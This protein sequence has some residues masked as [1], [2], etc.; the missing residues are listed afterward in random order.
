[1]DGRFQM[2]SA[3]SVVGPTQCGKTV[4]VCNLLKLNDIM[5]SKSINNIYWFFGILQPEFLKQ[6]NQKIG[7]QVKGYQGLP[8]NFDMVNSN[9]VIVLD[10]LMAESMASPMVTNLFTKVVHHRQCFL[11]YITQNLFQRGRD[12]RTRALNTHYLVMFK[13]PRDVIQLSYL[14]RQMN[15]QF[16]PAAFKD[17]IEQGPYSYILLDFRQETFEY[18]RIRSRILPQEAP[19]Y[20]YMSLDAAEKVINNN[21]SKNTESVDNGN[22]TI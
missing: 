5:F 8:K 2:G 6:L 4:F 3:M 16:L 17:A 10:D 1:M 9:D 18:M 22:K 7:K 21:G 15:N 11:I 13:N 12:N 19:Q 20:V 14:S